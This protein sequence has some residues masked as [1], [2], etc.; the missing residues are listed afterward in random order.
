MWTRCDTERNRKTLVRSKPRGK[1]PLFQD[2]VYMR[3][4]EWRRLREW[5]YRAEWSASCCGRFTPR[6]GAPLWIWGC[7]DSRARGYQESENRKPIRKRLHGTDW[8]IR[9]P[10]EVRQSQR[11]LGSLLISVFLLRPVSELSPHLPVTW[12]IRRKTVTSVCYCMTLSAARLCSVQCYNDWW[13][14]NWKG[15]GRKRPWPNRGTTP[16]L[17]SRYRGKSSVPVEIRNEHLRITSLER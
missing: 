7:V 11:L 8:G 15:S 5:R 1:V 3:I 12:R 17:A 16:T 9:V 10:R 13:G 2:Q 4:T 14:I 6:E